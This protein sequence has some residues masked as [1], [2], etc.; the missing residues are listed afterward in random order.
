M[1]KTTV[2]LDNDL[3]L[4]IRQLASSEGRP[5]AEIIREA[6]IRHTHQADRPKPKRIGAFHSGR[7]DV[8]ERSKDLIREAVK[9]GQWP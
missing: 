7:A 9:A 2:Y 5:Q 1:V 3:A 8:S 6:L 4:A